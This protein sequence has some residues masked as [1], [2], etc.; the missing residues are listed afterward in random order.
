MRRRDFLNG[1]V[2]LYAGVVYSNSKACNWYR[3]EYPNSGKQW[4]RTTKGPRTC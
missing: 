1:V 2:G 3:Q 4:H